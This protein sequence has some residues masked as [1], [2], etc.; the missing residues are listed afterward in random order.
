MS[1]YFSTWKKL[2]G[3]RAKLSTN[4]EIIYKEKRGNGLE[5]YRY[6]CRHTI[7]MV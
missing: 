6:Q 2:N 4:L 5:S 3:E 1:A 7:E